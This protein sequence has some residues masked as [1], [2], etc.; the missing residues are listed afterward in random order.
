MRQIYPDLWQSKTEN[1]IP[2][3]P[4][5]NT[6][7][8]LLTREDGNV[9]FYATGNTAEHERIAEMGGLARQYLSHRDEVGPHLA[10]IRE[11]FGS[12]LVAHEAELADV[13]AA[14]PVDLVLDKQE[15]HLGN[16][17]VIPTPGHSPGSTCYLV[18]SPHGR[19]Y[20]FTGDT[21]FLNDGRWKTLVFDDADRDDLRRSLE[22]LRGLEPDVILSSAS[23]GEPSYK[24]MAPG[25]WAASVEPVLRRLS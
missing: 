7:A 25:E 20:L 17:E 9:L 3:A 6:H 4:Q 2:G 8:Y 19:R 14:A 11:R 22:V 21:V 12:M 15:V 13:G 23:L 1:P 16:I 24:E 18:H 10:T 5:V